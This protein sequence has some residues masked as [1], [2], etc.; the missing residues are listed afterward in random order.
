[1]PLADGQHSVIWNGDD[2]KGKSVSSGIYFYSLKSG[3]TSQTKK[4][5]LMK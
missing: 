5:I 4:M 3:S 2:D 1:E